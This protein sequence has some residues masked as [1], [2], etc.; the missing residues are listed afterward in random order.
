MNENTNYN[1]VFLR[2]GQS[3]WNRDNRFI[4]WTDTPLTSD[5]VLEARVAGK[6]MKDA[7]IQFDNVHT[8][9]LRR[10]IRTVN[11]VLMELGQEYLHVSKHWRLNERSYGD[12]VGKNKKEMAKI[13]GPDKLREWRRGYDTPPMTPSHKYYPGNLKRYKAIP[14]SSIPLTESLHDT[15]LRSEVYWNDVIAPE[16]NSGKTVLVVGHENNLRSMI[17]KLEGIG[18]DEVIGLSLP[19]A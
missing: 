18:E 2:H 3:T 9:M 12:L 10:S 17:M 11:M 6:M 19:R 4:G 16:L 13:Y 15:V 1:L 8:S 14:P 7:G 5:G